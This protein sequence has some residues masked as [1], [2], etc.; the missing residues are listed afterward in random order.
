MGIGAL[1]GTNN[2]GNCGIFPSVILMNSNNI[3][4]NNIFKKVK[5]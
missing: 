3:N 1:V 4:N 2:E 5:K